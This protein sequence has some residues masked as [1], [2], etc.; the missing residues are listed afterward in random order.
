M[1]VITA[2][3][4]A[5]TMLRS[6]L[7]A[8]F[9]RAAERGAVLVCAPYG[10]GKTSALAAYAAEN[11]GT[12]CRLEP[13]EALLSFLGTLVQ[14]LAIRAPGVAATLS[15]AH[16]RALQTPDPPATLAS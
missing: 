13:Q 12:Y 11:D 8:L 14:A 2:R 16:E 9:D 6:R 10:Y 3:A 5:S 7:R 4:D 15:G 1:S